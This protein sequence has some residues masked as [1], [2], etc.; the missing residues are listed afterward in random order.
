MTGT[1]WHLPESFDFGGQE[2]RWGV[3]GQGDP[4]VL[5]HGTPFSSIEWR[6][7]A[8]W[9]AA[10]AQVFYFDLLGYGQSEKRAGQDVSL[11]VQNKVLSALL[12]HWKLGK[13]DVVAHDF[14]GATALRA[15]LLNG[16]DYRSLT[17][18]DPVAIRPWGSPFVQTAH[19]YEKVFAGLPAYIHEAILRAYLAGTVFH[20]LREEE[21]ALYMKPWLGAEGQAAFYRQIAQMDQRFT[22]EI[23]NRFGEMRCP[24]TILWGKD[25]DWIPLERGQELARR[26]P[27]AQFRVVP[28]AKHLVQED[29]PEAIVATVL[30]F[31]RRS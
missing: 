31:I 27:D 17:L 8:P 25:D 20:A 4:L 30:D 15:H 5:V 14:G 18:I 11:G 29:A 13:P 23:E 21:L 6:R 16:R 24:V 7:I 1:D 2:I 12:D 10:H 22:D 3:Q 9:L 28:D 19:D 26:I